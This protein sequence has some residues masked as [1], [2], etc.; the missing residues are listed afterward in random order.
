VKGQIATSESDSASAALST[1]VGQG[2]FQSRKRFVATAE[3]ESQEPTREARKGYRVFS[4]RV[5]LQYG[6]QVMLNSL[7]LLLA[8]IFTLTATIMASRLLFHYLKWPV[9]IDVTACLV[10]IAVGFVLLNTEMKLYPGTR[11]SPVEEL[12]RLIV[13]VTCMFVVWAIG[14]YMMKGTLGVQIEFLLVVYPACAV[15]LPIARGWV[16]LLMGKMPNWGIPVLVCG[17]DQAAVRLYHWLAENRYLGFRAVGI[18]GDREGLAAG[19]DDSWYA[20]SWS[21]TERVADQ[22]HVFW[23]VVVP[24]A[25]NPA[26]VSTL[27][28]DHLYTIPQV[29]VLTELTGLPDQWNPQRLDGLAGIHL[30]Q[31][32]MLPLPRFTKRVMDLVAATVGG[33]LLLPLLFYIAVAVKMSSRGPVLYANDRIGRGGRRF[34]MWKFRSMFTDGDAVL[35][36]YLDAHPDYREE[37]E[38]TQKLRTDPRITRIGRFIRKTSLDELPQLWNVLRG[39]MSIVGPRPILLNEEAKYG[40]YYGLYTMVS[41]GITGMWQVCG[42]G[43]TSYDERLQLV[44]YYV[45]NW[46]LWLDLYLLM[47]TA[48]IVLFGRGAY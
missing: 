43:N 33:I 3:S 31:N 23:A 20:G 30:Q 6:A 18:I 46:S 44:A 42:R 28:A 2:L 12:R 40:E 10:P 22:R 19:P 24:P 37:W 41:P 45:R 7:P 39:D 15:T 35:E 13:S 8:D 1:A 34:R 38:T 48:R 32:L 4:R 25:G 21:D 14:V 47:K 26:A 36:D 29:H 5:G 16:R 17:D 11:L 27:I 9:G